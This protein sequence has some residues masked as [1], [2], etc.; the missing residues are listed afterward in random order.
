MNRKIKLLL[1]F[2]RLDLVLRQR[3]IQMHLEVM[4]K[5]KFH[6]KQ[7]FLVTR[8]LQKLNSLIKSV[9]LKKCVIEF[10]KI[11]ANLIRFEAGFIVPNRILLLVQ[12]ILIN[13]QTQS[14]LQIT[15]SQILSCVVSQKSTKTMEKYL[16]EHQVLFSS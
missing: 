7:M 4:K 14:H 13:H 2:V 10:L 3:Q 5:N 8:I 1:Q 12:V 15:L 9:K 16:E 11:N 6:N